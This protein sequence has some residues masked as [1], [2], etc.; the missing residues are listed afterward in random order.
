M[1]DQNWKA[2]GKRPDSAERTLVERAK[3]N[4]PEM[5]STKQLVNLISEVYHS[6]MNILDVGCNAGH[7]LHGLRRISTELD[8]TGVDAYEHY[9][10]SAKEIFKN[11]PKAYFEVKDIL[12]PIFPEKPFDI[13]FCCNVILHLPDFRIAIKN[14]LDST[15]KICIIR[16]L[17]GNDTSI[18]KLVWD[19]EFDD[20]GNPLDYQYMNTWKK[21]YI[22]DYIK[23]LGWN[24]ELIK[25]E[26][27]PNILQKEYDALK[28]V[29]TDKG[30]RII[31]DKQSIANILYEYWWLKITKV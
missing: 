30:T 8:Y 19:H 17:I 2:W 4:L 20:N 9:I 12:K 22:V 15:K 11:D 28:T 3:G 7:Y 6:E 24:V 27:D 14:L 26:F 16:T 1:G 23:K 10:K 5:E 29:T 31:N 21:E 25:D 13:V 18:V